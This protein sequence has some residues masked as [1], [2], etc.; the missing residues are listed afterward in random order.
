MPLADHQVRA[1]VLQERHDQAGRVQAVSLQSTQHRAHEDGCQE[2]VDQLGAR[3]QAQ[4]AAMDHLQIIVGE[5]DGAEGQGREHGDPDEAVGQVSPQQRG[6]QHADD[7]Q[8][9]AHGGRAGFLLV[10]LWAVLANVLADLEF[11]QAMNDRRSDDQSD[12]QCGQAGEDGA[13]RQIAEDSERADVKDDKSFLIQQP[14]EQIRPRP[15]P[16]LKGR[17]TSAD[18]L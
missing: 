13:K 12:E 3:G 7:D 6:N 18:R 5:T 2:L 15:R 17:A 8:H 10:G 16:L 4:V 11:A 14:I 9:A 1:E